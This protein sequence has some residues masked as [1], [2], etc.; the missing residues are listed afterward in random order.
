MSKPKELKFEIIDRPDP[1]Y[2][3]LDELIGQH[4]THLAEAKIVLA[5][6]IDWKPNTDGQVVLGM[7]RKASDLD[8]ELHGHD[9][10]ILLNREYWP[11]FT[12][13]QQTAII[14]H[15]LSH[16]DVKKGDD[17][18]V[19]R[20]DSGRIVY[21]TRRHDLEEFRGVVERHGLYRADLEDFARSIEQA[22]AAPL[23]GGFPNQIAGEVG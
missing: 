3:T 19:Q 15:E 14:D 13:E 16:A 12:A 7:C 6:K 9:F 20:D 23:F 11:S 22:K 5:W 17:G 10:V 8:R 18:Q 21:R 1:L 4:H 2:R